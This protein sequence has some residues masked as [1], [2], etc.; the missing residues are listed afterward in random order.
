MHCAYF[1]NL[2]SWREL[3]LDYAI[4]I[5]ILAWKNLFTAAWK[6]FQESFKPILNDLVRHRELIES[7][8]SLEQIQEA[9]DARY[10][11]EVS[12]K[13][14]EQEQNH[15]KTLAVISWLS[16]ADPDID[17]ATFAATRQDIAETGRWILSEPTVK[18]WSDLS[19]TNIPMVWLNGKPG[20]GKMC[21]SMF[22]TFPVDLELLV[23]VSSTNICLR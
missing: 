20:A 4:L 9:R 2:V 21:L 5:Y 14:F 18:A 19:Q 11:S 22:Q 15:T 23:S 16:A 3:P 7:A 6:D 8:A 13:A 12:F 10:Q 1:H 17:Q